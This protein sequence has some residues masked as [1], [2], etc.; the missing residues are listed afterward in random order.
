MLFPNFIFVPT[1][2]YNLCF[3]LFI[4]TFYYLILMHVLNI[5]LDYLFSFV[6]AYLL[7]HTFLCYFKQ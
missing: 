4:A 1:G 5:W 6:Y 2:I 3:K 7:L